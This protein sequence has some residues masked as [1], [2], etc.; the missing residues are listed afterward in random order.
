M[1]SEISENP[2]FKGVHAKNFIKL[3]TV[4][5]FLEQSFNSTSML[6]SSRAFLLCK[7]TTLIQIPKLCNFC[8]FAQKNL[9]NQHLLY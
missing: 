7:C 4:F 9:Y 5:R 2:I 8:L 6:F 3:D 1:A